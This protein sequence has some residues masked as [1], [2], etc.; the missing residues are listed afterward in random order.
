MQSIKNKIINHILDQNDWANT[1]LK[2]FKGKRK[3]LPKSYLKNLKNLNWR[4]KK[5][6]VKQTVKRTEHF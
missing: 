5:R 4:H 3:S 2:R 6:E 1:K